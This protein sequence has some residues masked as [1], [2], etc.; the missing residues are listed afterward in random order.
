MRENG[1]I[2]S[3]KICVCEGTEKVRFTI[4]E[5]IGNRLQITDSGLQIVEIGVLFLFFLVEFGEL[6]FFSI[7]VN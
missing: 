7:F 5:S 4:L 2:I 3:C 6:K 1:D